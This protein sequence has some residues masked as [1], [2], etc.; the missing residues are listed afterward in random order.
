MR[1][2]QSI[3]ALL[4]LCAG[5]IVAIVVVA[6]F[7]NH[8]RQN[9]SFFPTTAE[10]ST[11]EAGAHARGGTPASLSSVDRMTNRSAEADTRHDLASPQREEPQPHSSEF[12]TSWL[13][14]GQTAL[15]ERMTTESGQEVTSYYPDGT[16]WQQYNRIDG[17]I[18]GEYL[19]WA[20]NGA[21]ISIVTYVNGV[22]HGKAQHWHPDGQDAAVGEYADG[23]K[24]GT[25]TTWLPSGNLEAELSYNN[26]QLHGRCKFY[27]SDGGL[28]Y[29][30]SGT[31]QEGTKV[32]ELE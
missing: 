31:Y 15:V 22:L 8:L 29:V 9:E 30:L 21:L 23:Q 5:S 17:R 14:E 26:G 7:R 2:K 18:H 27:G 24:Q 16:R 19:T 1:S 13:D 25:W 32:A 6:T 3:W 20:S 4:V 12:E 28:D 11:E 10:S